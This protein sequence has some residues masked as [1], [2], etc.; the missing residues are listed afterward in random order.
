MSVSL[1]VTRTASAATSGTSSPSSSASIDEEKKEDHGEEI[2]AGGKCRKYSGRPDV[3]DEVAKAVS[4][5][6]GRTLIICA[7][8]LLTLERVS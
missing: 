4:D 3:H 8:A 2:N 7:S 1:Y 5:S 6:P